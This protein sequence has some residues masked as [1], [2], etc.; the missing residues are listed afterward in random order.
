MR[1]IDGLCMFNPA[2]V[3]ELD[4]WFLIIMNYGYVFTQPVIMTCGYVF[5]QPAWDDFV[6]P[7][8][9]LHPIG[10]SSDP[11]PLKRARH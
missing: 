3:Y 8:V 7:M 4:V 9:L 2:D 1:C 6:M 10:C 11:H 5:T